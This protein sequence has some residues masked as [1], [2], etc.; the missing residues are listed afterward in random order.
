METLKERS[1]ASVTAARALA[2]K[3]RQ[4][5][6]QNPTDLALKLQYMRMCEEQLNR[7]RPCSHKVATEKY[8]ILTAA[9]NTLLNSQ[10]SDVSAFKAYIKENQAALCTPHSSIPK[11]IFKGLITFIG[12]VLGIVPGILL[13]NRFF[14]A[15]RPTTTGEKL[16]GPVLNETTRKPSE[17][18]L[19]PSPKQ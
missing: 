13:A 4:Q 19:P 16:V 6:S 11:T 15:T 10:Q 14:S 3:A 8:A 18:D 2:Q 1:P 5:A 17:S 12:L 9:Y 7:L